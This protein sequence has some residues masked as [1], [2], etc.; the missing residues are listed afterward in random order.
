MDYT[1]EIYR[2]D[3]RRKEG[4]VLVSKTDHTDVTLH[5]ME[6][7]Y[8]R[9]PRYIVMIYET[10]VTRKNLMTGVEYQERYDTPYFCSPAS[11]SYWSM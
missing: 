9:H 2:I 11:E 4:M 1:I 3:R 7:M 5:Q 8:P 6:W 10:Y